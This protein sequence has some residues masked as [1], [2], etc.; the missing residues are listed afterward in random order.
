MC[1]LCSATRG[2]RGCR[3]AP[4]RQAGSVTAALQA[5]GRNCPSPNEATLGTPSCAGAGAGRSWGSQEEGS[6]PLSG[7]ASGGCWA[8][9]PNQAL[10]PSTGPPPPWPLSAAATQEGGGLALGALCHAL[11]AASKARGQS[12]SRVAAPRREP[13]VR[14]SVQRPHLLLSSRSPGSASGSPLCPRS[15]CSPRT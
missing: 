9:A 5:P 2:P 6:P 13:G 14:P 12:C 11:S 1:C 15:S 10:Q 8:K 4:A 3:Q 7:G